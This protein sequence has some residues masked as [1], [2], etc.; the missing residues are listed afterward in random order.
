VDCLKP[1][2]FTPDDVDFLRTYANLIAV[3][4]EKLKARAELKRRADETE[5]LLKELQHRIKNNL[6]ILTSR[7]AGRPHRARRLSLRHRPLAS[8]PT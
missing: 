7:R 5:Q 8:A 3:V 2:A 1:R 6:Q 4:V